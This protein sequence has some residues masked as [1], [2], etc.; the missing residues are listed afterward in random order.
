MENKP[1]EKLLTEIES[2][3]GEYFEADA[4][5]IQQELARR[6]SLYSGLGIKALSIAGGALA[7]VFFMAFLFSI[8]LNKSGTGMLVLGLACIAAAL[9]LQ[10][11][12]NSL[13]LDTAVISAYAIGHISFAAGLSH[14]HVD[15]NFTALALCAIS[16]ASILL[17]ESFMLVFIA[18]LVFNGGLLAFVL[19]NDAHYFIFLLTAF[20]SIT[21]T[22]VHLAESSILSGNRKLNIL[23]NPVRAGLLFSFIGLLFVL[24]WRDF[25]V[26]H[27]TPMWISSAIIIAAV[28]LVIQRILKT[29]PGISNKNHLLIYFFIFLLLL[30]CL[31][32]PAIIGSV[33]ILLLCFHT[34]HRSGLIL[35]IMSFAFFVFLYYYDLGY[36]L[37]TKSAILFVSGLL[38]L[39]AWLV[40]KKQIKNYEKE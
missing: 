13:I 15:E 6:A 26:L 5:E 37:L 9:F 33:L 40:F 34:G 1:V 30:P 18:V 36:T 2:A 11:V 10:R 19:I 38:F 23:Y 24:A 35:A 17:T 25:F 7:G 20:L 29:T 28:M 21:F 27:A 4:V 22:W 39:L 12:I 31:F 3:E 14:L 16:L 8:G 32:A